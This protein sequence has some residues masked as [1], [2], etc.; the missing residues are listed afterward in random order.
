MIKVTEYKNPVYSADGVNQVDLEILTD[1]YGWV[2]TTIILDDNDQQKHITQIKQ[3]LIDN[4]ESIAP[5]I[6]LI[7]TDDEK[8]ATI[9]NAV[10]LHLNEAAQAKGY[11]DINSI[12]K[13]IGYDNTYRTE[14]EALGAWTASC[15]DICYVILAGWEAGEIAEPTADEVVAQLPVIV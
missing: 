3:W 6:P 5:Y 11:D 12:A 14:C 2:P 13:Y 7:V 8:I 9:S 4:I 15:W 1:K 10:Q